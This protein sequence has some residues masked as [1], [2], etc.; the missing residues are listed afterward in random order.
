MIIIADSGSTKTHWVLQQNGLT[1]ATVFTQGINPYYV[2]E[3]DIEKI[4]TNE[5][6]LQ[7]SPSQVSGVTHIFYYG[8]GCSTPEM[9]RQIEVPLQRVF[10]KARIEV[11]HDLLGAARAACGKQAG[12]AIILGTGSNSCLYNGESIVANHPSLG[13]ILGDEGSGGYMGKKLLQWFLYKELEET[14][15][16]DFENT[17]QLNKDMVLEHIYKK[18]MPNR[19]AASFAPFIYKHLSYPQMQELVLQAFRDFFTHHVCAYPDY[20]SYSISA[21]GS[22]AAIFEK[23]LREIAQKHGLTLLQIMK[24]PIDGL[25]RYHQ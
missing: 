15:Y 3:A 22:I 6:V 16:K 19:Y 25:I 2:K 24:E 5:L 10:N 7:L 12:I 17:Y 14:L 9:C 18:P 21:V 20:K 1:I 11:S 13:F 23:Q 4:F 8:A